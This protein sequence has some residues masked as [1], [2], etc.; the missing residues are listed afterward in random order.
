MTPAPLSDQEFQEELAAGAL[1]LQA[2]E[3][4]F[5]I[6]DELSEYDIETWH[7]TVV[8]DGEEWRDLRMLSNADMAEQCKRAERYLELRGLLVR[9]PAYPNLVRVEHPEKEQP[10][11][12]G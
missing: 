7:Y 8:S 4:A 10:D 11:A 1:R 6:A 3:L 2:I 12:D 9:N 5:A